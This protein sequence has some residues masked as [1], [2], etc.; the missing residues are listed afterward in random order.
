MKKASRLLVTTAVL[1][2]TPIVFAATQAQLTTKKPVTITPLDKMFFKSQHLA[3]GFSVSLVKDSIGKRDHVHS[4]QRPTD[5]CDQRQK[6]SGEFF[7]KQI[8]Q[9]GTGQS[10]DISSTRSWGIIGGP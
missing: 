4:T 7:I 10:R 2:Y 9:G 6:P 8:I 1:M 5:D 3:L